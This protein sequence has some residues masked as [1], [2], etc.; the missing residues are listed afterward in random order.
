MPGSFLSFP[1]TPHVVK[2][3]R[4]RHSFSPGLP[5][6]PPGACGRGRRAR[7]GRSPQGRSS[8][9][10]PFPLTPALPSQ[11][12]FFLFNLVSPWQILGPYNYQIQLNRSPI[13]PQSIFYLEFLTLMPRLAQSPD[14]TKG[15]RFPQR[16]KISPRASRRA[17]PNTWKS[18][19]VTLDKA[20]S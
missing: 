19:V 6:L 7:G 20:F 16:P 5:N 18:P 15:P 8:A 3:H 14:F 12:C 2:K 17:F 11:S 4:Q 1:S 13:G 10:L 9:L